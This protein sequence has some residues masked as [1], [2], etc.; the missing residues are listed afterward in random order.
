MQIFN[1]L[2]SHNILWQQFCDKR[3]RL[4]LDGSETWK[5]RYMTWLRPRLKQHAISLRT[6]ALPRKTPHTPHTVK[7]RVLEAGSALFAPTYKVVLVSAP[8]EA[9]PSLLRRPNDRLAERVVLCVCAVCGVCGCVRMI[10]VAVLHQCLVREGY[11]KRLID[12]VEVRFDIAH[13]SMSTQHDDACKPPA[14]AAAVT[15]MAY[16]VA[17]REDFDRVRLRITHGDAGPRLPPLLLGPRVCRACVHVHVRVRWCVCLRVRELTPE[18]GFMGALQWVQR[19]M[20]PPR[21]R[22]QRQRP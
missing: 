17:N 7:S 13:Y 6:T 2:C 22:S 9:N 16:D 18:D 21:G 12:G 5:G 11:P 4:A 10:G 1:G 20:P 15:V 19:A 14:Q 8:G 3:W